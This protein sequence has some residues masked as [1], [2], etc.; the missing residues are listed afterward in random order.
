MNK[1]EVITVLIILV[2]L[3]IAGILSSKTY[4]Y[5]CEKNGGIYVK[6]GILKNTC[7]YGKLK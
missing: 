2:L 5:F 4:K 7:I 3:A 1:R 6:N